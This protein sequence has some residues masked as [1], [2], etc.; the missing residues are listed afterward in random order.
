MTGPEHYREAESLL[1][2]SR[3]VL[4]PNDDGHCEADRII[5]EAQVH[6]TLATAPAQAPEVSGASAELAALRRAVAELLHDVDTRPDSE[7]KAALDSF[8]EGLPDT[9]HGEPVLAL[10]DELMRA[11]GEA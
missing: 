3:D 9:A 7:V 11:E 5:A 8:R 4:R 6:A 2:M 1:A 10:H